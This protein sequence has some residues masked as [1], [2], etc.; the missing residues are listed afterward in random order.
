MK[1]NCCFRVKYTCIALVNIFLI[2]FKV[3][4]SQF[5]RQPIFF[6]LFKQIRLFYFFF[7]LW[8]KLF[9]TCFAHKSFYNQCIQSFLV[10]WYHSN[11]LKGSKLQTFFVYFHSITF[12]GS[13]ITMTISF[14]SLSL[15]DYS[16][17]CFISF[18]LPCVWMWE[19]KNRKKV[20]V[21]L[22]EWCYIHVKYSCHFCF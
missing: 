19:Q 12:N 4:L 21:V 18:C 15:F 6:F 9:S 14:I 11:E 2:L 22:L 17:D 3:F 10:F 8:S 5:I 16:F 20:E 7:S 13:V 1:S